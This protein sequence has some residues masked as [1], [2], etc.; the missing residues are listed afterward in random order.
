MRI[1]T[2]GLWSPEM[3]AMH[4]DICAKLMKMKISFGSEMDYIIID[5]SIIGWPEYFLQIGGVCG[6]RYE[7]VVNKKE[8]DGTLDRSKYVFGITVQLDTRSFIIFRGSDLEGC[9]F[10]FQTA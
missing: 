1:V 7:A 3:A 4:Q 6:E 10:T 9:N 2:D 5:G 8:V